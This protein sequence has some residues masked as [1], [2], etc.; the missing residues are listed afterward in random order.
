[1]PY[2]PLSTPIMAWLRYRVITLIDTGSSSAMKKAKPGAP[3]EN[4]V[5]RRQDVAILLRRLLPLFDT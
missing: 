5:P 1:M 3:F 4:P 2:L